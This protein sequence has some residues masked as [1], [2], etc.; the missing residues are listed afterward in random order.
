MAALSSGLNIIWNRE[1]FL[2]EH[3]IVFDHPLP[4]NDDKE[5]PARTIQIPSQ[6]VEFLQQQFGRCDGKASDD[7]LSTRKWCMSPCSSALACLWEHQCSGVV[8]LK[9]EWTKPWLSRWHPFTQHL[10]MLRAIAFQVVLQLGC[11]SMGWASS[12]GPLA[13][14]AFPLRRHDVTT[15]LCHSRKNRS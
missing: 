2:E 8:A 12:N 14:F 15:L 6:L 11:F 10:D 4:Q 5:N 9:N 3:Q 13:R 7:S 1:R